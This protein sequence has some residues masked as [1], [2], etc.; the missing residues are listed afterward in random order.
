MNHNFLEQ[1]IKTPSPSGAEQTLQK[2]WLAE[3]KP[4]V[5][6]VYSD[7]A[8]NVIAVKNPEA[9]F[10]VMLAGHCDEIAFMVKYI[11]KDGFIYLAKA[12]GISPK[13]ALGMRVNVLGEQV[14]QGVIGVP[15]EHKGGAKDEVKIED[16]YIDVGAKSDQELVN[17]VSVGDYV[18]YDVGYTPLLNR[19]IAGRGLDNR[20]GAYIVAEVLKALAGQAVN[21]GVYGVSTVNEETTMGG[22]YFAA[23]HIEPTMALALDVTFATDAA[24]S[25]PQKDGNVALGAGPV[26]SFGSQISQPVNRLLKSS[27]N[28]RNHKLQFELTPTTTGT[29]ADKIRFTGKGVPVALVSLPLR[30]MHSP[31]E[32][33]SLDDIEAEVAFLVDFIKDLSGDECL[34]PLGSLTNSK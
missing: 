14:I 30:Y 4:H 3:V 26:L 25:N 11:D 31:S 7:M 18:V 15:P 23:Q 21:V 6:Q 28:K 22:A 9:P 19:C 8:G 10:K 32:V 16:I 33:V 27:A 12:G 17:R 1:L 24:G 5:D 34:K 2:K 20:T 29:D 13:V